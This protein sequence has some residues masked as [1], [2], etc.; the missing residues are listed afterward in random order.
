MKLH[1]KV[2]KKEKQFLTLKPIWEKNNPLMYWTA[3]D[4]YLKSKLI[5]LR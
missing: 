5:E 1:Q 4:R 2:V 3:L